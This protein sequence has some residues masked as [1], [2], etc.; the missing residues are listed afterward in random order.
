MVP[1]VSEFSE[2]CAALADAMLEENRR[3]AR[4]NPINDFF[5]G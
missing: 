3:H 4:Y 2:N 1:K 5:V